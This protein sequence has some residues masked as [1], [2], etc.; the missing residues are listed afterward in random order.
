MNAAARTPVPDDPCTCGHLGA[1]HHL[2]ELGP[3]EPDSYQCVNDTDA[4]E[5]RCI[6]Y[7]PATIAH[8]VGRARRGDGPDTESATIPAPA[9]ARQALIDQVDGEHLALIAA[10]VH[11]SEGT[12]AVDTILDPAN[13]HL[14]VA[15]LVEA[16]RLVTPTP[17]GPTAD[18]HEPV[19]LFSDGTDPLY[20]VSGGGE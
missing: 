1:D 7:T 13:T 5:C 8:P 15:A 3:G 19:W 17:P 4:V 11:V 12:S 14:V 6:R 2:L 18:G 20:R 9:P 10:G 16:G